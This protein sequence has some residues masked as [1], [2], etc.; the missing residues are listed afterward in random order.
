MADRI[1]QERTRLPAM[2][3]CGIVKT[4]EGEITRGKHL[5]EHDDLSGVHREVFGDMKDRMEHI[6]FGSRLLRV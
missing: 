1:V 2:H 6:Y 4:I 3:R 5:C